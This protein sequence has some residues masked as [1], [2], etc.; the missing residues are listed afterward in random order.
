MVPVDPDSASLHTLSALHD[1]ELL[2]IEPQLKPVLWHDSFAMQES[3]TCPTTPRPC[4]S[5]AHE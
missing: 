3:V 1:V 5:D 4:P 2:P